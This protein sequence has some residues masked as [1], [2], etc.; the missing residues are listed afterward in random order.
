MLD[1]I[2]SILLIVIES[3]IVFILIFQYIKPLKEL[4]IGSFFF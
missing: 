1:D 3:S 4:I 2:F